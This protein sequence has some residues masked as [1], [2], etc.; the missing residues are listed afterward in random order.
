MLGL[1]VLQGLRFSPVNLASRVSKVGSGV[2]TNDLAD[3]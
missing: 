1:R 2:V 3:T